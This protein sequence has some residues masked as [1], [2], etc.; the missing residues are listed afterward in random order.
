MNDDLVNNWRYFCLFKDWPAGLDDLHIWHQVTTIIGSIL[1]KVRNNCC[2]FS[3][4]ISSCITFQEEA[5]T[6]QST[7]NR[8]GSLSCSLGSC[9]GIWEGRGCCCRYDDLIW[10]STVSWCHLH[11]GAGQGIMWV[12]EDNYNCKQ[13]NTGGSEEVPVRCDSG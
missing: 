3:I 7:N 13:S 6:G 1:R 11:T 10:S 9:W 8:S 4:A 2:Q 12:I 5:L